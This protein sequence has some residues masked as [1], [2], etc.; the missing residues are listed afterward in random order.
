[1]EKDWGTRIVEIHE[2]EY[3]GNGEKKNKEASEVKSEMS[4]L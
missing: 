1:M 2:D 3:E 4:R